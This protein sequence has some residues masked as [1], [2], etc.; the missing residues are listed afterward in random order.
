MTKKHVDNYKP[1]K[2]IPSCQLSADFESHS[3]EIK[4]VPFLYQVKLLGAKEPHNMFTFNIIPAPPSS[5]KHTKRSLTPPLTEGILDK[6]LC[7]TTVYVCT[8]VYTN[9]QLLIAVYK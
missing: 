5:V 6:A 4:V 3:A 7:I 2:R 1:G 9:S 8:S